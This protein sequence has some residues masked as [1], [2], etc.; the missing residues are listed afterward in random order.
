MHFVLLFSFKGTVKF[1]AVKII[2]E[3]IN[4]HSTPVMQLRRVQASN[5]K[6]VPLIL[7]EKSK[8]GKATLRRLDRELC[9]HTP[10][11]GFSRA[12]QILEP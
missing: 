1:V 12:S 7:R 6:V 10:R 5:R 4:M 8:I 11:W 3:E 9:R 2:R